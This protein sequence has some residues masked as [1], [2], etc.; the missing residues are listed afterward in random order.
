MVEWASDS[1]REKDDKKETQLGGIK[2]HQ[3]IK[4]LYIF[5]YSFI[6]DITT[7]WEYC[8]DL[9]FPEDSFMAASCFTNLFGPFQRIGSTDSAIT[10]AYM[11]QN[12]YLVIQL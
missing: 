1:E 7:H 10:V 12:V 8:G 5:P 9:K 2:I 3:C 6:G 4:Y 11:L